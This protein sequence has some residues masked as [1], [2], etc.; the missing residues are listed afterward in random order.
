MSS[1]PIQD[2]QVSVLISIP[3]SNPSPANAIGSIVANAVHVRDLHIQQMGYSSDMLFTYPD[4]VKDQEALTKAGISITWHSSFDASK[5][6][7]Q[8]LVHLEPDVKATESAFKILKKDMIDY[9]HCQHFTLSSILYLNTPHFSWKELPW[10]GFLFPLLMIDSIANLF[11]F[12]QHSRTV[13]M[14]VQLVHSTWPRRSRLANKSSW[15]WWIRT[16]ICWTRPSGVACVQMPLQQKDRGLALVLRTI[17]Q[18]A[19]M[20]FWKPWWMAIFAVYYTFFALPWWTLLFGVHQQDQ[21]IMSWLF[22]RPVFADP[23]WLTVQLIHLIAVIYTSWGEIE[24]PANG[25]G[26]VF[27]LYPVYL[28]FAPAVFLF[29]RWHSSRAIL[30]EVARQLSKKE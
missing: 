10:Y 2:H 17:K 13:D 15:R 11:T 26:F 6:Q 4:A 27:L 7:T 24:L 8:A 20:S 5:L 21:G 1:T 23:F 28:T 19:S 30:R 14:R 16:G 9:P 22:L 12:W 25:E 18:H 29:G 3:S